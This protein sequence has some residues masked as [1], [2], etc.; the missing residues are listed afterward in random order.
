MSVE[1]VS[2]SKGVGKFS[3]RDGQDLITDIARVSNPKNQGKDGAGLVKY[4]IDN[5]HWSPFEHLF[6]T[7][8]IETTRAISAQLCRHRSFTFQEFSQRYSK[9][10]RIPVPELRTKAETNR[11][12]SEEVIEAEHILRAAFESI[13]DSKST[14]TLLLNNGVAKE[15]ARGLLP[16]CTPTTLYMTGSIRSWLHFLAVRMDAHAQKEAQEIAA[17]I[18]KSLAI[19]FPDIMDAWDRLQEE[20]YIKQKLWENYCETTRL[21]H[22]ADQDVTGILT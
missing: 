17:S 2:V 20:D 21:E 19:E 10:G 18:Y 15:T 13:E 14:Y 12:S 5:K 11:Q 8:E 9:V 6:I 4:L 1:L 7:F 3:D 22:E 16:M